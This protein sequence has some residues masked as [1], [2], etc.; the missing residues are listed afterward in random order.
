MKKYLFP[1]LLLITL[2]LNAQVVVKGTVTSADDKGPIPGASIFVK[3][4]TNGVAADLDGAYSIT[5]SDPMLFRV[6]LYCIE[7]RKFPF[8]TEHR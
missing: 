2:Q 5:V 6:C 3:G 1:L 7:L 4:T 8:I